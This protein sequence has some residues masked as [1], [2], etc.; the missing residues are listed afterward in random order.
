MFS[1]TLG[2]CGKLVALFSVT[3][4]LTSTQ[5]NVDKCRQELSAAWLNIERGA[6]DGMVSAIDQRLARTFTPS[7]VTI[8]VLPPVAALPPMGQF[9]LSLD[10]KPI[11]QFTH[12]VV[13]TFMDHMKMQFLSRRKSL[14][15]TASGRLFKTPKP[16]CRYPSPFD[17]VGNKLYHLIP[18]PV[19][20]RGVEVG[21]QKS[22]ISF[23]VDSLNSKSFFPSFR[24][25]TIL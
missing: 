1:V 15:D 25:V 23:D 3:S 4:G 11:P 24:C 18:S 12:N 7:D 21:L 14:N 22:L 17:R 19:A 8:R 2:D 6:A 9:Q 10:F 16:L 5:A 13:D 20:C